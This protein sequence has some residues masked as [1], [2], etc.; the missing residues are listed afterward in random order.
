MI[1]CYTPL[2]DLFRRQEARERKQ[3]VVKAGDPDDLQRIKDMWT[4]QMRPPFFNPEPN[5]VSKRIRT[6][7]AGAGSTKGG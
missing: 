6:F 4:C 1:S 5:F 7:A 3:P 2:E